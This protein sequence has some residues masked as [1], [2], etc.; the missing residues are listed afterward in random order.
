MI[1][2]TMQASAHRR[3]PER[4]PKATER[5]P[6][7][8]GTSFALA[9]IH[10]E[11]R[12]LQCGSRISAGKRAKIGGKGATLWLLHA[13]HLVVMKTE[14]RQGTEN[15]KSGLRRNGW[16]ATTENKVTCPMASESLALARVHFPAWH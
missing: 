13:R 9:T 1:R 4:Q 12:Q 3:M 14:T 15:S 7:Q 5:L 6:M 16:N 2:A 8:G 11:A 10:F